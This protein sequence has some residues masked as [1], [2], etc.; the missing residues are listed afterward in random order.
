[1]R[2]TALS[3]DLDRQRAVIELIDER[4]QQNIGV[5]FVTHDVN[6]ILRVVDR[7]LYFARGGY[8]LGTP[9]DVFRSDVLSELCK[10]PIEVIRSRGRII[11]VGGLDV[12]AGDVNGEHSHHVGPPLSR[13]GRL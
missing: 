7:V 6:P 8:C 10:S 11:V 9:A 4:R 2:R 5:L 3:L 12:S 1:M 13:G